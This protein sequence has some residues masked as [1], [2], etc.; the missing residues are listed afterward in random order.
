M[1]TEQKQCLL[2]YLG[3]YKGKIDG[4]FGSASTKATK[5]FQEAYGLENDGEFGAKTEETILKAITG[6][7]KPVDF[8]ESIQYFKKDEFKCKCGKHCNGFPVEP[9]QTLIRVADR[10]RGHFGV[11]A[12]VSSGV[13]C[14]KHN[15]AVGGVSGSRHK[16]G[17]AM[18]FCIKGKTAQE[19]L[20][21]VKKQPEIRY[22]Y[23]I[24]SRYVHMDVN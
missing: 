17:K 9:N 23:A 14:T 6:E 11:T 21:Y 7:I 18:D 3:F 16:L 4:K 22:C 2:Y 24:D 10:V 20:A 8:W 19:V 15:S 1:T 5:A 12:T 13:R